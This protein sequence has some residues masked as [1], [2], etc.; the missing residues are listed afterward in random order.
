MKGGNNVRLRN[1]RRFQIVADAILCAIA[2]YPYFPIDDVQMSQTTMN[3]AN[4]SFPTYGHNQIPVVLLIE[5]G[6]VFDNSVGIL[7]LRERYSGRLCQDTD[8]TIF[9]LDPAPFC[10]EFFPRWMEAVQPL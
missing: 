10:R 8:R 9:K 2:L 7:A 6:L 1:T 4:S 3:A 5:H